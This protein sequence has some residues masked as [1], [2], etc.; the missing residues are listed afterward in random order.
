VLES[1]GIGE[2]SNL[3]QK[4]RRNRGNAG[5]QIEAICSPDGEIICILGVI[6]TYDNRVRDVDASGCASTTRIGNAA[7]KFA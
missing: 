1:P 4:K 7:E 6:V 2:G 3:L 5:C